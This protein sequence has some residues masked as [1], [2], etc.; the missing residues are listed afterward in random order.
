MDEL[1]TVLALIL[2]VLLRVAIPLAVTFTFI[3]LLKWL[4]E[5]WQHE[6]ELKG[7][8]VAAVGNTGCWDI[9][10]CPEG[11]RAKCRAYANPDKPCWQVFRE[12]D[13]RL[14]ERCIGCDIFKHSP[15]PVTA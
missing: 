8:K 5:R 6:A 4:D 15:K 2:G 10:N 3:K 12:K 14:Q 9:N 7:I 13:G 11:D 1:I